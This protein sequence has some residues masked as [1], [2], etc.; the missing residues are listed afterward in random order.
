[1]DSEKQQTNLFDLFGSI[2]E[3]FPDNPALEIDDDQYTYDDLNIRIRKLAKYFKDLGLSSGDGVVICLPKSL[4]L[5]LSIYATLFSGA[6]YIP[7]DY[8]VPEKRLQSIISNICPKL[9][10]CGYG[11]A[12]K[13]SRV[14]FSDKLKIVAVKQTKN[15]ERNLSNEHLYDLSDWRVYEPE[16]GPSKGNLDSIAYVLYTSGST[17]KPKGIVHTHRSALAFVIWAKEALNLSSK[18][19]I[20]NYSSLSFDL[21]VFD[22]FCTAQAGAT[23]IPVPERLMGRMNMIYKFIS[24]NQI[25]IWY[26]VP[27]VLLRAGFQELPSNSLETLRHCVLAGE[28]INKPALIEFMNKIIG[29][30]KIHNWYGPTETN[31]ITYYEITREGLN[32]NRPVSIGKPCPYVNTNLLQTGDEESADKGELLVDSP[33]L[34]L[35]YKKWDDEG[36]ELAQTQIDG[37]NYY[38]TGDIVSL[39][40]NQDFN[41]HG[42]KD[43]M[44]KISGYRIDL[45]EIESVLNGFPEILEAGVVVDVNGGKKEILAGIVSEVMD[46]KVIENVRHSCREFLPSY[47]IPNSICRLEALPRGNREKIDYKKLASVVRGFSD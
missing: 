9:V 14:E 34:M 19:R 8:N 21:S 6:Y 32:N 41:Y 42:R 38:S 10:I 46:D 20:A 45:G 11:Q 29:N 36:L 5:Y 15:E 47:M 2:A 43:R 16:L 12:E 30:F 35:G 25:T 17:G 28:V 27:S 33:T 4:E 44:E 3:N 23:L 7:I 22:V 24:R 40:E 39:D 13:I 37:K 18:D 26:S 31:V 1:M